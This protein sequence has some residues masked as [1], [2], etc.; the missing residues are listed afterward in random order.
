MAKKKRKPIRVELRA[1]VTGDDMSLHDTFMSPKVTHTGKASFVAVCEG[2]KI[3][4]CGDPQCQ[5]RATNMAAS[6]AS[7]KRDTDQWPK[8]PLKM[9]RDLKKVLARM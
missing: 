8:N 5:E 9:A 6:F 4:C 7:A 2:F 1:G 3:A